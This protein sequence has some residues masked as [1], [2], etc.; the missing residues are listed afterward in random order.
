MAPAKVAGGV[1][2]LVVFTDAGITTAT[3][4]VSSGGYASNEASDVGGRSADDSSVPVTDAPTVVPSNWSLI[5]AGLD[6]GDEF[7]LLAKTKILL[8]PPEST[9]SNIADYNGHVQEQI[10]TRGHVDVQ[11]YA[12]ALRVLG[13]TAAVNA[14]TTAGTTGSDGVPIYWLKHKSKSVY[15]IIDGIRSDELYWG[16]EGI[17]TA[18]EFR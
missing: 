18:A 17:N 14:R 12:N 2:E 1:V 11:D 16:A 10:R 13:S 15:I 9:S 4:A 6:P 5:P 3:A 7:R 8:K